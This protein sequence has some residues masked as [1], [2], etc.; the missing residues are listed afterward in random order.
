MKLPVHDAA[1]KEVETIDVDDAVFGVTPNAPV[2]HQAFVTAMANRRVGTAST[3]TRG[4]V[5]GSTRKIRKQKG[6]GASR[7]GAITAPQ[8]RHGGIVHGPKPRSYAKDLPK[9]MRRLAI[10]SVLSAKAADGSLR[11]VNDLPS[12]RPSTKAMAGVIAAFGFDRSVLLV[13][14]ASDVNVKASVRNL[15]NVEILTAPYLNVADMLDA[16][17]LLMTVDAVRGAEAMWGGE[18]AASKRGAATAGEA[19]TAAQAT[20]PKRRARAVKAEA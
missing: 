1:G 7:Q 6:T 15:A 12:A 8:H 17:A 20:P 14:G 19:A 3:K 18:K 2:V 11:I 13:T 9:R 4:E 10:R 5:H 16:H